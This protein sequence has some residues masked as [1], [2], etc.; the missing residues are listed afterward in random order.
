MKNI[1]LIKNS[2]L[3]VSCDD[4]KLSNRLKNWL[5]I[6][7][8]I[9]ADKKK[10]INSINIKNGKI[11]VVVNNDE[12]LNS[13]LE[14]TDLYPI[15]MNMLANL[16]D[17]NDN[18]LL[19]STVISKDGYG[20]LLLGTFGVGKTYLSL[21]AEQNGYIINSA[22]FSWFK[23]KGNE[24]I[25]IKGSN[26]LKYD[27]DE[28]FLSKKY[29]NSHI[30]IKCI[31]FLDGMCDGN[32][33]VFEKMFNNNYIMRKTFPFANWHSSIPLI[34]D[35]INLPLNNVNIK[36]CLLKFIDKKQNFISF[37]GDSNKL[38][39]IINDKI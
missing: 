23:I 10:I 7:E 28:R 9:K 33:S 36:E 20:I 30:V 39:S 34:S 21:V 29:I 38:I 31:V 26:Y 4:V 6:F 3:E 2:K 27:N 14:T 25:L 16:I 1:Y 35:N 5:N 8:V 32:N 22:D 19:H 12:L 11:R 15:V 24:L 37:R 13:Y 18:I 17:D